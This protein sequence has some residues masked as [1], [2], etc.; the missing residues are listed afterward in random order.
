ML[1]SM[2]KVTKANGQDV[3]GH[4]GELLGVKRDRRTLASEAIELH[5]EGQSNDNADTRAHTA[6]SAGE[7]FADLVNRSRHGRGTE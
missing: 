5:A 2:A 1:L 4:R 7:I 3:L 6:R